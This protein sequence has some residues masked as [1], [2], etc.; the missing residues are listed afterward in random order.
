MSRKIIL[1]GLVACALFSCREDSIIGN[2]LL[3][4]D[5]L[6]LEYIDLEPLP[7]TTIEEDSFAVFIIGD[8]GTSDLRTYPI[9]KIDEP[10]FGS[11]ETTLFIDIHKNL[12]TPDFTDSDLDSVVLLI[13]YDTLG[14]Y[15]NPSASHFIE[16]FEIVEDISEI[17]TFYSANAFEYDPVSI[18][19]VELVPRTRD[20][21][22]AYEPDVDS[23]M[24]FIPHLRIRLDDAYAMSFFENN[25]GVEDDTTFVKE[26]FGFAIKSTPSDNSFFGFNLA[27]SSL[28]QRELAVYYSKGDSAIR[29]DFPIGSKRSFFSGLNYSGS[30][31]E[32]ALND[33]SIGD[34]LLYV[35]SLQG[36]N[37]E[38][39]LSALDNHSDVSLNVAELE[40]FVA[41]LPEDD[42]NLYPPIEAFNLT[43]VNDEGRIVLIED[44]AISVDEGF[45]DFFGGRL[46]EDANGLN[47]YTLGI[48]SHVLNILNGEIARQ[49]NFYVW[50]SSIFRKQ[51]SIPNNN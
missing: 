12:G 27:N 43:Y 38:I 37:V 31:V 32:I 17:D 20:T 33:A 11:T 7:M 47:K 51:G 22:Y 46:E 5:N 26:N 4:N 16:V 9:G 50:H 24:N 34:S 10:I 8:F 2:E 36:V 39:D 13:P 30:D 49:I 42:Q 14:V 1:V 19:R 44:Y 28:E 45:P 29:Y 41:E 6:A 40:F 15:G 25:N 21:V 3:N 48:T 35:Q 18:G 23:V